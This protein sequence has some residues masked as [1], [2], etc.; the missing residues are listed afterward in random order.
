[1]GDPSHIAKVREGVGPWNTWRGENPRL[2]PDLTHVDLSGQD[3]SGI[4]FRGVGLF[5]ATLI[6]ARLIGANLRQARL[7]R[8]QLDHA[9]LTGAHVYGA[10]VW[11]VSLVDAV[12]SDLVITP[13]GVE[14]VTVDDLGVAQFIYLLINNP[15]LRRALDAITQRVVLILG[16]FKEERKPILDLAKSELRKKGY[17]PVMFDF[18]GPEN[19]DLTETVVT[20]AHLSRFVVA[21]LTDPS[22][23]PHELGMFVPNLQVPV[24][25]LIAR[26]HSPYAMFADM[27]R[28]YPWLQDP[29]GYND[30][31][32]VETVV[33]PKLI[34]VA[35]NVRKRCFR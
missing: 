34:A 27:T 10:S 16:R 7:V 31:A 26:G 21:D 6:G 9:D 14:V 33:L 8:T 2:Q 4:D 30:P 3:L 18:R 1:V 22:C 15:N 24:V 23:I 35:E 20:L 25:T 13:P 12:Q 5:E 11:D 32:E 28:K 29:V 17:V 19:R